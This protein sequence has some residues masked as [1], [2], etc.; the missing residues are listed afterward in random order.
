VKVSPTI[1]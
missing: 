1:Q